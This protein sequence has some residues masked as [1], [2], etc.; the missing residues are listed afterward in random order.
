MAYPKLYTMCFLYECRRRSKAAAVYFASVRRRSHVFGDSVKGLGISTEPM[1]PDNGGEVECSRRTIVPDFST[2][3]RSLRNH[4][5][6]EKITTR[7]CHSCIALKCHLQSPA[8]PLHRGRVTGRCSCVV[9]SRHHLRG[10][11]FMARSGA[12]LII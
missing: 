1:L 3:T 6:S 12:L 8:V 7:G 2:G 4:P 9:R 11:A 10:L 5:D